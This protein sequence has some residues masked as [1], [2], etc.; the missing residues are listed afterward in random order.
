MIIHGLP[1]GNNTF[2]P[3]IY[4][5]VC[6]YNI[7]GLLDCVH[8]LFPVSRI[9]HLG[10]FWPI[11]CNSFLTSCVCAFLH[12]VFAVFAPSCGQN[13]QLLFIN[14]EVHHS[15]LLLLQRAFHPGATS[16]LRSRGTT[17]NPHLSQPALTSNGRRR[18]SLMTMLVANMHQHLP[19]R[20]RTH[21][22]LHY[23]AHQPGPPA[24]P[25]PQLHRHLPN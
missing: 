15:P 10:P 25:L 5:C 19:H 11:S 6:V 14:L 18:R 16:D 3:S 7:E 1:S 22:P 2:L 21:P 20:H 8:E 23:H 4:L 9:I 24:L 17:Y 13:S 12:H